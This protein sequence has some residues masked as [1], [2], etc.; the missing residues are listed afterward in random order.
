MCALSVTLCPGIC[1]LS[2]KSHLLS[3]KVIE[4]SSKNA[5][6]QTHSH[7][8]SLVEAASI[9]LFTTCCFPRFRDVSHFPEKRAQSRPIY[10]VLLFP[11]RVPHVSACLLCSHTATIAFMNQYVTHIHQWLNWLDA[12]IV[13]LCLH[14]P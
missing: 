11:R 5:H 10:F 12:K 1:R 4:S 14:S 9:E 6:T 3:A 7:S 8:R 13:Q 2:A